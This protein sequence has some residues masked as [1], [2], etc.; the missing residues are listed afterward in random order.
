MKIN[1]IVLVY[2]YI[3]T[4]VVLIFLAVKDESI[5]K[6]QTCV[7]VLYFLAE[8]IPMFVVLYRHAKV[9]Y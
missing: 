9:C 3:V 5:Q 8:G 6:Y 2:S 7:G 4:I 1:L